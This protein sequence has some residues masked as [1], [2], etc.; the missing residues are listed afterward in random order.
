[1]SAGVWNSPA[2]YLHYVL[3]IPWSDEFALM[4]E[5]ISGVHGEHVRSQAYLHG[6][7]AL[8]RWEGFVV[9]WGAAEFGFARIDQ[10]DRDALERALRGLMMATTPQVLTREGVSGPTGVSPR[11]STVTLPKTS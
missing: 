2:P 3:K 5:M 9:A 10:I 6:A 4:D 8:P 11:T 7:V 1:M